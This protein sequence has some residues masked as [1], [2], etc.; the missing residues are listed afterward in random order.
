MK[1]YGLSRSRA[2]FKIST[3]N[4]S[5]CSTAGSD[6]ATARQQ[7][8]QMQRVPESRPATDRTATDADSTAGDQCYGSCLATSISV[9][10]QFGYSSYP[11]MFD[12]QSYGFGHQ[13]QQPG[14][15]SAQLLM[16]PASTTCSRCTVLRVL[17]LNIKGAT[18]CLQIWCCYRCSLQ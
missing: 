2:T 17:P 8:P 6:T 18:G 7:Q 9:Q 3:S 12:T 13:Y 1:N 4:S 10:N 16:H 11:G 5:I 14:Q 15:A